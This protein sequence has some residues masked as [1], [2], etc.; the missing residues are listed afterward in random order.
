MRPLRVLPIRARLTTWYVLVLAAVLVLFASGTAFVLYWQ[1][2][3]QLSRFAIQDV[4]TIEGLLYFA[5]AGQL[6]LN[7]D[8]HNH[9]QSR[10]VLER[11]LEVFS[12]DGSVLYQNDRL[13]GE[14]LGGRLFAGEGVDGYSQRSVRLKDGTRVLAVS[15]RHNLQGRT[16]VIRLGYSEHE[17]WSRIG[18][19]LTAS[20]I[21]LPFLLSLAALLGYQLAKR[22][23]SPLAQMAQRA[24]Q[25]TAERLDQRLPV[26]NPEDELGH[27]ARVFNSVLD[28]LEGS[29]DQLRRFTSD[30]SHELRTPLAAIRS[31]GEVGLQKSRTPAD[32]RDTI[33][34]MLEEVTR[35]TKLVETLLTISRADAGQIQMN[36]SVF[37]PLHLMKEVAHLVEILTE[38]REQK[39]VVSGD[40]ELNVVGDR[41]LLRQA[42]TNL[43]HNA[44]KYSPVGGSIAV[45]VSSTGAGRA[46]VKIADSGPGIPPEHRARIFDRFYRIDSARARDTGGAGLGLSIAS[47]AI[48]VQGGQI[49]VEDGEKGAIFAVELPL[50]EARAAASAINGTP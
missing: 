13:R 50:G 42:F 38:E 33:G 25:I 24:E 1:L 40:A 12:A 2:F 44:V 14:Q 30:A 47:W 31:V 34:S 23:L 45:S 36:S 19:F 28:R 7:E 11:L 37:S 16:V 39:L 26:E 10:L 9:P 6:R 4:E 8:Y 18:E 17:I 3:H 21:A 35:L 41:L 15:R 20:L 46:L 29:F 27:L 48:K 22:T 32:Y 49:H 5:P 43:L